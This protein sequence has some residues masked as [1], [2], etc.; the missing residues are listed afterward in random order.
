MLAVAPGTAATGLVLIGEAM[1]FGAFF[2]ADDESADARPGELLGRGEDG[3]AVYQQH[4]GKRD[5]FSRRRP[6][7]LHGYA[8]ALFDALLFAACLDHC[9]HKGTSIPGG[10]DGGRAPRV[11]GAKHR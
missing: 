5:L 4:R 11:P 8:L 10:P 2:L 3:G 6:E 9:V 1:N 7:Q